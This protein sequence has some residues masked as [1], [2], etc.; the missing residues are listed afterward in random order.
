MAVIIDTVSKM[1]IFRFLIVNVAKTATETY[2]FV[3][4]VVSLRK[5]VK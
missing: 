2:T 4:G 5:Y 3:K 1:Y